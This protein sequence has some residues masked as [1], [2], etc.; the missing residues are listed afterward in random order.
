MIFHLVWR[1]TTHVENQKMIAAAT[2][3]PRGE[4]AHAFGAHVSEGL[5]WI[6]WKNRW[7]ATPRV[8]RTGPAL[9]RTYAMLALQLLLAAA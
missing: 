6:I 2:E 7:L 8:G 9:R 4:R 1:V 5:G 3:T